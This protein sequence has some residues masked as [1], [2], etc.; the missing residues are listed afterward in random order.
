MCLAVIALL[1][2]PRYATVVA[3]NRDEFHARASTAAHAWP[4]G[5]FAG[6]DDEAGGTWFGVTPAGRFA[7]VTN[8]REPGRHDPHAPSRGALVTGVLVDA[9]PI[10]VA[11]AHAFAGGA[12]C[13]GYNLVAGEGREA[14]YASNRHPRATLEPGVHG[15]SNGA[16]DEPWPKVV[17]TRE[18]L[19]R[20]CTAGDDDLEPL[21]RML[22]DRTPAPDA[23]L[24]ATGLARERERLLSAPFIVDPVY[25]TRASTIV[26]I[27]RDGR[28]A[29]AERAFDAAG[30]IV[31]DV[32][33]TLSPACVAGAG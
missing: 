33:T 11:V 16:L 18:A 32:A 28:V 7:F 9:A 29:F 17:R 12:D 31:S 5:F 23:T 21:W 15:V 30:R 26:T 24:P 20:W 19:A 1:A 25:G 14:Y 27:D 13:N 22:A 10:A 4:Q 2:H 8:V 3:A 6:R